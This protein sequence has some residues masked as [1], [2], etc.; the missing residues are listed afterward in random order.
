MW[1]KRNIKKEKEKEKNIKGNEKRGRKKTCRTYEFSHAYTD[2]NSL[3]IVN[4][5]DLKKGLRCYRS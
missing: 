2:M 4:Y 3:I 5:I 1:V